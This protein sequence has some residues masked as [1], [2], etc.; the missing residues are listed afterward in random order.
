MRT[1]VGLALAVMMALA[2]GQV[3]VG[4][5]DRMRS[6]YELGSPRFRRGQAPG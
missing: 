5:P 3:R 4:R 2:L 6:L 1:R